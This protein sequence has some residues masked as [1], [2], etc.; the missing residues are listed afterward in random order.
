M[1]GQLST[2]YI[3]NLVI[4]VSFLLQYTY[5]GYGQFFPVK[6]QCV[7]FVLIK[8]LVQSRDILS[9]QLSAIKTWQFANFARMSKPKKFKQFCRT[10]LQNLYPLPFTKFALTCDLFHIDSRNSINCRFSGGSE[11]LLQIWQLYV[12]Y[13][14]KS[15]D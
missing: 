15:N 6:V 10:V 14:I 9:A 7:I 2:S 12:T 13:P 5:L 3:Y 8:S 1:Y 11:G 4:F